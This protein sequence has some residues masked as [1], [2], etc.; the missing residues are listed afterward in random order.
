VPHHVRQWAA[1][2]PAMG[3]RCRLLSNMISEQTSP[4][5]HI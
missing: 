5:S 3:K 1:A 4:Q 2:S